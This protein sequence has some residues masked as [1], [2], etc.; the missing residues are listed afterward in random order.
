[1]ALEALDINYVHRITLDCDTAEPKTVFLVRTLT[2]TQRVR[3]SELSQK[4]GEKLAGQ[5]MASAVGLALEAWECLVVGLSMFGGQVET[6]QGPFGTCVSSAWFDR[7]IA[8]PDVLFELVIKGLQANILTE[9]EKKTSGDA[10]GSPP[11]FPAVATNAEKTETVNLQAANGTA[12]SQPTPIS[13]DQ[14][15]GVV[16]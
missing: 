2:M 16:Q 7:N 14:K 15:S 5:D 11:S 1:M 8:R 6:K 13:T 12:P 9:A 4:I 3:I 10:S